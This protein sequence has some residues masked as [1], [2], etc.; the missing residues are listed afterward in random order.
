M[1]E[2]EIAALV[3]SALAAAALIVAWIYRH[4]LTP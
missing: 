1:G 4:D 3:I 2:L